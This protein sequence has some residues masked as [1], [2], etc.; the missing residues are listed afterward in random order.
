MTL[1]K[2]DLKTNLMT[3]SRY[4]VSID[5]HPPFHLMQHVSFMFISSP[6][7]L[8]TNILISFIESF[9]IQTTISCVSVQCYYYYKIT[10]KNVIVL[11]SNLPLKALRGYLQTGAG[12]C[13]SPTH[14]LSHPSI[15][16]ADLRTGSGSQPWLRMG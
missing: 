8:Q 15:S 5:L 9:I 12:Q 1:P 16:C 7:S 10:L 3:K 13:R 14:P 11:G 2:L 6:V 4:Q